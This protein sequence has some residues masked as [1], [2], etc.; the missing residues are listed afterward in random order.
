LCCRFHLI[1]YFYFSSYHLLNSRC[2]QGSTLISAAIRPMPTPCTTKAACCRC[3]ER[4]S[5]IGFLT[6][7]PMSRILCLSPFSL[8]L[9][10]SFIYL[11]LSL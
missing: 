3:V 9:S 4:I 6:S 7:F 2:Y 10:L 5:S 11:S 8:S 1:V